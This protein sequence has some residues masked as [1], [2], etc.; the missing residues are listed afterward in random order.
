MSNP[1]SSRRTCGA[2][3]AAFH[4]DDEIEI[5]SSLRQSYSLDDRLELQ[6][7]GPQRCP[8]KETLTHLTEV[9]GSI[10]YNEDPFP[11]FANPTFNVDCF[12]HSVM[13]SKVVTSKDSWAL[14]MI[15]ICGVIVIARRIIIIININI[16]YNM[17]F[18]LHLGASSG[19]EVYH[20]HIHIYSS[21][22]NK[23]VLLRSWCC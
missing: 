6:G 1:R 2:R 8:C 19:K 12:A 13:N 23:L 21:S 17:Y 14:D 18:Y 9:P 3:V 22:N 20:I 16:I 10:A 11:T 4:V 5:S 7:Q 15:W